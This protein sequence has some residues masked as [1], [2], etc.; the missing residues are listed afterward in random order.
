MSDGFDRVERA[1]SDLRQEIRTDYVG[2]AEFNAELGNV[3][4]DIKE[5]KE[6]RRWTMGTVLIPIGSVVVSLATCVVGF[7]IR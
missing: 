5:I 1:V 3:K 6:S 4:D 7:F 2:R